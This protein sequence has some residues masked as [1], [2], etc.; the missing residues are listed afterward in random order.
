MKRWWLVT[1]FVV[2]LLLLV[3]EPSD[4]WSRHGHHRH[5]GPRVVV[6]LGVGW[7]YWYH[8]PSPY[9]Y[10]PPYYYNPYPSPPI[11]IQQP[12]VYVEQQPMPPAGSAP[13]AAPQYWYYCQPSGAYYPNVQT[14]A[15]PWVKVPWRAQ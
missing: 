2:A 6:G 13:A 14:C 5:G 11:V 9:Y 1:P 15:E 3:A 12:P 8:Y 4:A 7:P 10:P